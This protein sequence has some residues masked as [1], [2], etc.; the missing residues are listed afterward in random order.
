MKHSAAYILLTAFLFTLLFTGCHDLNNPV[1]PEAASYQGFHTVGS[2][3]EV[4]PDT[5]VDGGT[6][7]YQLFMASKMLGGVENISYHFTIEDT[8]GAVIFND[9]SVAGNT[10]YAD[11][12]L[13]AGE[14]LWTA[15]IT[16]ED[17][18]GDR[19]R[20]TAQSVAAES[21]VEGG[22]TSDTTPLIAWQDFTNAESYQFQWNNGS[23]DFSGS[24]TE[25]IA[26]ESPSYQVG[27]VLAFGDIVYWRARPV[28]E[29]TLDGNPQN[30]YGYWSNAK[31]FDIS[32]YYSFTG[33]TPEDGSSV[34]DSSVTLSWDPIE[35]AD[36][37]EVQIAE[38][39]WDLS[40]SAIYTAYSESYTPWGIN[41]YVYGFYWRIRPVNEDGVSGPSWSTS[42]YCGLFS[43]IFREDFEGY[44]SGDVPDE[45]QTPT[46]GNGWEVD[47]WGE[48]YEGSRS[49]QSEDIDS[50]GSAEIW[51]DVYC[52]NDANLSFWY[53]VSS[54]SS[55]DELHFYIDGIEQDEWSGDVGW[56][57]ATYSLSSGTRT[58]K[59]EY[60]KDGSVS[61]GDDCAWIDLVVVE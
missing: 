30:L 40:S 3:S 55:Y 37:Y 7:N 61:N 42:Y 26:G 6:S 1:D 39:S 41:D 5:P 24:T 34:Q 11:L 12:G 15:R 38:T 46:F 25:D 17:G 29:I 58:L 53:K 51:V 10:Y 19:A 27:T 20:F 48:Y 23:S 50:N 8:D 28:T 2:A 22:S 49:L 56:T 59:W 44:Y 14:Y 13:T 33:I 52:P 43:E 54:E 47:S 60:E 9:D 4:G 35:G 31:S 16:G 36:H 21:P 57:E 32:W 45:W 18:R